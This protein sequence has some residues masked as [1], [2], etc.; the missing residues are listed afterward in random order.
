[1]ENKLYQVIAPLAASIGLAV[2]IV[3]IAFG[4]NEIAVDGLPI[5]R[6]FL[7]LILALTFVIGSVILNQEDDLKTITRGGIFAI[8]ASFVVVTLIGGFLS[9]FEEVPTFSLLL[10]SLSIC[11]IVSAIMLKVFFGFTSA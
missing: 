11:I 5:S 6:H 4:I 3:M 1:M 10:S 9:F 7:L 8:L 2:I